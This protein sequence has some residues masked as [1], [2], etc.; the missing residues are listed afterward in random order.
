[1]SH[2]WVEWSKRIQA[3]AQIGLT[4]TENPFDLERYRQ[5]R[6]LSAEI[7]ENYS[8]HSFEHILNFMDNESGYATPKVDVRGV[9]FRGNAVLLVLEKSDG[10]WTLPGG[11]ADVSASPQ[12]NVEREVYEESGYRV[13]A[14][15]LMA[16]YD[17]SL[18]GHQ[19]PHPF[20]V[21]K[22]F[23]LCDI[24]GGSPR[25]SIETADATFFERDAI[26]ELSSARVTPTQIERL[27]ELRDTDLTEFD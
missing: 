2:Q 6:E 23:F 14:L 9:V 22:L 10:H 12:K 19:P 21:Y 15:R 27:F 11:W 16:V 20:H 13:N 5:L 25:D 18:H 4:Y 3:I 24:T 17:R 1:M 7:I 8:G 26:P